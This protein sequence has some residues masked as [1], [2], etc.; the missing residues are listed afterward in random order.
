MRFLSPFQTL[1]SLSDSSWRIDWGI[2]AAL[3]VW[4]FQGNLQARFSSKLDVV[5]DMQAFSFRVESNA[6]S[7]PNVYTQKLYVLIPP[8][9]LMLYTSR[10]WTPL[11]IAPLIHQSR[12]LSPSRLRPN[13]GQSNTD[14]F[15]N[16][17]VHV[18]HQYDCEEPQRAHCFYPP[19]STFWSFLDILC[20]K[21]PTSAL[22]HLTLL[23]TQVG[24]CVDFFE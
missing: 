14:E 2:Q 12:V 13:E 5:I 6:V 11:L 17:S 3:F 10:S 20:L 19:I 9:F 18:L 21:C 7:L 8:T 15:R 1:A 24:S 16:V 23:I 22:C 4:C